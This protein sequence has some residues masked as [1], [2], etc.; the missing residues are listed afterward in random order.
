MWYCIRVWTD[1]CQG[2]GIIRLQKGRGRSIIRGGEGEGGENDLWFCNA[3]IEH[4][5]TL[6]DLFTCTQANTHTHTHTHAYTN[7]DRYNVRA[8]VH[9]HTHTCAHAHTHTHTHTHTFTYIQT[10]HQLQIAKAVCELHKMQESQLENP[11]FWGQSCMHTDR[12]LANIGPNPFWNKTNF[13]V[14]VLTT[15]QWDFF[16]VGFGK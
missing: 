5:A 15:F 9:T 3:H 16:F 13:Y 6:T 14:A 12:W 4:N 7:A 10:Q 11:Q 1:D 8:Y 2:D